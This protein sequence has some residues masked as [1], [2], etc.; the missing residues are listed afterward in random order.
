MEETQ[1]ATAL[2]SP[3]NQDPKSA[4]PM[5]AAAERSPCRP[6]ARPTVDSAAAEADQA[7]AKA[8]A[9]AAAYKAKVPAPAKREQDEAPIRTPMPASRPTPAPVARVPARTAPPPCPAFPCKAEP[10][11]SRSLVS[12]RPAVMPHR[13]APVILL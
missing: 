4:C 1:P 9:P 5:Q 8:T 12:V 2:S 6:A 7:S 10:R 13:A 11:R 3:A